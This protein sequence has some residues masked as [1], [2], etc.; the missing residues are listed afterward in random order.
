VVFICP[1]PPTIITD[2]SEEER[3]QTA[4]VFFE[5]R[6][7]SEHRENREREREREKG[8]KTEERRGVSVHDCASNAL[9]LTEENNP[10]T[11]TRPPTTSSHL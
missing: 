10:D 7:F 4:S 5:L 8:G 3:R 9:N 6:T 2:R 1:T 11:L